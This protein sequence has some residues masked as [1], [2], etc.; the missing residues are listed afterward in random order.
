MLLTVIK[1]HEMFSLQFYLL[2]CNVTIHFSLTK[3]VYTASTFYCTII[4]YFY[5]NF[6]KLNRTFIF[7]KSV[8]ECDMTIVQ[9]N[10][11]VKCS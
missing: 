8:S 10:E 3:E 6:F 2:Q 11:M 1:K 9:T 4:V 5:H 7:V